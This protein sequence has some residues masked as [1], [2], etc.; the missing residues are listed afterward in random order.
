[1]R[2]PIVAGACCAVFLVATG[3][4]TAAKP[5]LGVTGNVARFLEQTNQDSTVDEAFL[6]WGQGLSYGAPFG[7]TFAS[8]T[9]IP[10]IH[11]GTFAQGNTREAITPQGIASGQGDAYLIALNA[12]IAQ[13]GK[14][15]YVRPLA[16]MNNAGNLWSGFKSNGQTKDAAHSPAS[17]RKAFARIF[18]IVHGGTAAQINATLKA[19]GMPSLRGAGDLPVNPFPRAR[20]LWSPL[21]GGNPNVAGNAP[22][23]Y[24][25]GDAYVD[26][27]GGDIYDERSGV[28]P[29]SKLEAL[30]DFALAHHKPF[31][32]PE[33]GLFSLDD[34]AFM[35]RMCAFLKAHPRTETAEFY[36]SKPGSIFDLE[37]KPQSRKVYKDCITPQGGPLPAWAKG[38]PGDAKQLD[39]KLTPGPAAGDS[40]LAVTFKIVA[41]LSVPIVQWQVIFGDGDQASASGTPPASVAH[42]YKRDGIYQAT[43]IV[44]QGPPFIGTAIRFLTTATVTVGTGSK[45]LISVKATPPAGK[46][47]LKVV[48]QINTNLPRPVQK[49]QLIYGDGL[50][51]EGDGDPPH[52]AG[53]TYEK[54]GAYRSILIVYESP[55]VSGTVVRFYTISNIAVR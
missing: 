45:A 28:P 9:P 40:P 23:Q 13:W 1:M 14:A 47:P 38:A 35:E 4:A 34:P 52:F 41:K 12:A 20:V 39:L 17:Y 26:V 33:W 5:L 11:L 32:I 7:I 49:W 18:L 24:W 15:I 31:S 22:E 54:P 8:L 51:K 53:H 46:A 44:Y 27:G 48:F 43:L 55:P 6:G 37:P 2:R 42:T 29:W 10:M 25:P 16:E 36:N 30:H 19:L 3:A 50:S 21:A